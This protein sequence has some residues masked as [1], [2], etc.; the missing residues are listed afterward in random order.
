MTWEMLCIP[1]SDFNNTRFA[2]ALALGS[3]A[4]NDLAE[5]HGDRPLEREGE[6]A[7]D[8]IPRDCRQG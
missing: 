4:D 5:I 6:G 1:F 3:G 7:R 2:R 8:P